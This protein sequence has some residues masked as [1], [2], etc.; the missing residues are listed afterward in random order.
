M[1]RDSSTM[2]RPV[3]AARR[4]RA[5]VL[6]LL[7]GAALLLLIGLLLVPAARRWARADRSVDAGR[8]RLAVVQ[9][10]DLTRDITAQGRIVAA[11]HPTLFSPAAGIVTL[12][13]KAG[14]TVVKGQVLARIA[15]P[16]LSSRLAQER[17]ALLGLESELGRQQVAAKQAALKSKQAVD[18]LEVRLASAER[19]LARAEAS[20]ADGVIS[21]IELEK[22]QDDVQV[23]RLEL[24]SA[25]ETARLERETLEFE[26][27]NRQLAVRRQQEA[28]A[29][30]QRQVDEL[31]IRA[32]FDGIVA[33][34]E[35]QD[36]DAVPANAA[37]M[38]VVDL[39]GFEVEFEIPENYAADVQPGTPAEIRHEA[40]LYRGRVQAIS[41]EIRDSQAKGTLAFDGGE[42]AGLRQGQRVGVRLILE[43]RPGVLKLARGPFLEAGGGREVYVVG[44]DGLATRRAVRLG[45]TSVAEVEIADGLAEGDQVVISDTSVFEGARTVL[46]N[47]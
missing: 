28:L 18:V 7:V 15:S 12:D 34:L 25:R 5:R 10:G 47:R 30:A 36:R 31:T 38:T 24:Q 3:A 14:T 4:P 19:L 32:P 27:Q 44:D 26:L 33:T 17:S 23:G 42:P 1:I 16:E 20:S 46:L 11:L 21:R 29:E 39:S 37:L 45:A 6:A 9:R 13:T 2:D 35:V 43:R 40:G 22:A 41:P 8:V